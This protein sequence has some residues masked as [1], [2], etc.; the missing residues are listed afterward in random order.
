[1]GSAELIRD[2]QPD[3][4]AALEALHRRS[5]DVWEED[6]AHLAAHPDAIE[7]PYEAIVEGRVRVAID[8]A[9]RRLGFSVVIPVGDGTW[10]LD[11]LFVE[12]DSMGF[13]VGRMLVED[14]AARATAAGAKWVNVIANPRAV[15]FYERLGFRI[16]G[17]AATRFARAPRMSLD[18]APN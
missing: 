3:E 15:G 4:A 5:S 9:G 1:M 13:G 14:V 7:S 6:R 11:D 10:E 2:A 8:G 12:P 18:L 17:E 16:T